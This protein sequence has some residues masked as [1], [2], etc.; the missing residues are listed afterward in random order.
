MK[1]KTE[2]LWDRM[3]R[4]AWEKLDELKPGDLVF[5]I[6]SSH[7]IRHRVYRWHN[8]TSVYL[9][10]LPPEKIDKYNRTDNDEKLY[11]VIQRDKIASIEKLI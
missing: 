7:T 10:H 8:K 11:G 3:E 9:D 4:E 1:T 5:A 2:S 6:S